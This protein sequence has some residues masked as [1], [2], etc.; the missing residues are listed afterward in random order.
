MTD[1]ARIARVLEE[2]SDPGNPG[3]DEVLQIVREA[4]RVA[5]V[6][7][8]RDPAK[9]ARRVPSYLAANGKEVIPINPNPARIF[10]KPTRPSLADVTEPVDIVL[11]FRPSDQVGP[12]VL[13]AAARP[14]RP[15]IWLQEGIRSD[16][17]VQQ[18]RAMGLTVVQDLCIYK[19][20]RL[21]DSTT[22]Q[23]GLTRG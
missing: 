15:V 16:A 23:P 13:Q 5:V 3:P 14:E 12:F 20:H 19:V 10:G 21:L 17:E 6:G 7:A 1:R 9:A 8:S 2:S 22:A 11:M 4:S 18:A